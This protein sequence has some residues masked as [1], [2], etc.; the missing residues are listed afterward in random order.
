MRN[1]KPQNIPVPSFYETIAPHLHKWANKFDGWILEKWELISEA[2]IRGGFDRIKNPRYISARVRWNMKDALRDAT[3]FRRI[4]RPIFC[5]DTVWDEPVFGRLD[6]N[7][8]LIDQAD[9]FAYYTKGLSPI[10]KMVVYQTFWDGKTQRE[11]AN[12]LGM[13]QGNVSYLLNSAL[14]QMKELKSE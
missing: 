3:Q 7:L 5:S 11:T 13:A 8:D 9:T 6:K 4:I 10:Q 14:K 2:W 12:S 1:I